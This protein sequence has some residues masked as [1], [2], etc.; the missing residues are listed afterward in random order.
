MA[1]DKF[2]IKKFFSTKIGGRE[3]ISKWDS[4]PRK[5]TS[6]GTDVRNADPYDAECDLHC[7]AEERGIVTHADVDGKGICELYGTTPRLY[8]NDPSRIKKWFNLEMTC[9]FQVVKK[10]PAG[11]AYVGLRLAGRSNHQNEYN[12]TASGT[13]YSLE[14]K[15]SNGTN[16]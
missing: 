6:N 11:G 7:K 16:Q 8:I 12:C 1:T 2:G 9:Y 4:N 3:W 14:S 13:G 15:A 10:L 5:W